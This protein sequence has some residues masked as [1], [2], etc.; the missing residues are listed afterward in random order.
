MAN[1]TLINYQTLAQA[2]AMDANV[3]A[4]LWARYLEIGSKAHDAFS[5]FESEQPR[6]PL[7]NAGKAGI[8]CR[9]RELKAQGGDKVHFTVIS[10]PG[11]PGSIGERS[12][13]G[14]ESKSKFK[15]YSVTVDW[16]RDAVAFTKKQIAFMAT[17]NVLE[18]TT[19][20]LLK[21]KMGLWKQND[22]MVG[23]IHRGVGNTYR[24][25]GKTSRNAIT[26]TD[27]LSMSLAVAAKARLNT[28]GAKPISHT[29]GE[30]GDHING[31]LL[32]ASEYA[33]L[34]IRNDSGYQNAIRDGGTRGEG[35]PL[36]TG[37]L[38]KWQGQNFYEHI[39]TDQDWDDYVG[40]PIQP[41]AIMT[42]NLAED[43]GNDFQFH[44][45]SAVGDCKL[46]GSST[47]TT[48]LYFQHFPGFRYEFTEDDKLGADST[49]YY[50]WAVNPDGTI[51]FLSYTGSTGNTGNQITITN[52]LS[53]AAGTS[54][55]GAT[56]VGSLYLGVGGSLAVNGTTRVLTAGGTPTLPTDIAS[57]TL[58]DGVKSGAVIIPANAKGVPIGYGF[59]FGAHA[60]CRAYGSVQMNGIEQEDDYSFIKGKG[61]EMVYGQAP[62]INTNGVTNGYLLLEFAIEHEGYPVP[63][64][65]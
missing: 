46:K 3:K 40:S 36:F 33:Y 31:Y 43:T 11:G 17:G 49:V 5:A 63:S 54:T 27:T 64:L 51:C 32:F 50:A 25:N 16:H 44:A 4:Q 26:K 2:T 62:T 7:A 21:L 13:K 30:N 23:L 29:M 57:Y 19:A 14:S 18:E 8:F 20:E 45:G 55:L 53:A 10:A 39:V 12:L 48:S 56:T 47:N 15:T 22:M 58:V 38:V 60:A 59:I 61:Y 37:K 24:P 41:K 35:N 34:D 42:A 1:E 52:I 28:M 6:I 9:R 65:A